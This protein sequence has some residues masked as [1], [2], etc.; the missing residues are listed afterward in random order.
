MNGT[1]DYKSVNLDSYPTFMLMNYVTL[2]K[3]CIFHALK[4]SINM[5]ANI[6]NN[7]FLNIKENFQFFGDISPSK[8]KMISLLKVMC[9]SNI[10]YNEK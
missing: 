6:G 5:V 7:V 8:S 9:G 4:S 2:D 10:V 1:F 3:L